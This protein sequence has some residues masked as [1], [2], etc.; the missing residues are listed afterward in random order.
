[1]LSFKKIFLLFVL[2]AL[3]ITSCRKD[4]GNDGLVFITFIENSQFLTSEFITDNPDVPKNGFAW[5]RKYL[6]RT[7][8]FNY[9]YKLKINDTLTNSYSG[10][11]TIEAEPGENERTF[12]PATTGATRNYRFICKDGTAEI[13]FYY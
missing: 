8:T 1:M 6:T 2:T 12:H 11:Y 7:G 10:N 3:V 5:E 9:S 13:N 4:K